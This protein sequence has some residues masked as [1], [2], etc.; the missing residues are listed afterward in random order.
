M[1]HRPAAPAGT[2]RLQPPCDDS[3]HW[4]VEERL[5]RAALAET[6]TDAPCPSLLEAAGLCGPSLCSSLPPLRPLPP[7]ISVC[8]ATYQMS[9]CYTVNSGYITQYIAI[10][11]VDR[12]IY[13]LCTVL[14]IE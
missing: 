10:F 8:N 2:C 1:V 3:R 13:M 5:L 4:P 7:S 12:L 9:F 11:S 6:V 14:I